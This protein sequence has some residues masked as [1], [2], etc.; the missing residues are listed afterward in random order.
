MEQIQAE[1]LIET[2][3]KALDQKD[4]TDVVSDYTRDILHILI[5]EADYMENNQLTRDD[6]HMRFD[7]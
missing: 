5:K 1:Q 6:Y 7:M 3:D 4:N 2:V